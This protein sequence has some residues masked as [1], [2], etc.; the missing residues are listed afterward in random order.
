MTDLIKCF[1]KTRALISVEAARSYSG[2][3][4]GGRRSVDKDDDDNED[5]AGWLFTGCSDFSRAAGKLCEK[6]WA[7]FTQDAPRDAH[8]NWNVFPLTLLACSVNTP[9]DNNRPH[10]LELRVRVLGLGFNS[11]NLLSLWK[12][13]R[14]RV[15]RCVTVWKCCE[16][17]WRLQ[18]QHYVSDLREG[19]SYISKSP[20]QAVLITS[21][22]SFLQKSNSSG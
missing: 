2:K 9:I 14:E 22:H 5:D 8:T 19:P 13:A 6:H 7:Q 1:C 3:V 20:F 11:N 15:A 16:K 17:H 12:I 18:I 4:C 10:L 21:W